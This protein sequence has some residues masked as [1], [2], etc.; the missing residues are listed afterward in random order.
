VAGVSIVA[1]SIAGDLVAGVRVAP[2]VILV[3]HMGKL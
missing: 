1:A 2:P 3:F